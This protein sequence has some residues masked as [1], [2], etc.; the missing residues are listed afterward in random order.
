MQPHSGARER[1]IDSDCALLALLRRGG[2]TS[3]LAGDY[4]SG[5]RISFPVATAAWRE[6]LTP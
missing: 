5:R 4:R 2:S 3:L 1:P 6:A